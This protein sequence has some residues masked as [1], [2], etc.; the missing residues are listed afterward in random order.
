[1]RQPVRK[2]ASPSVPRNR[3]RSS[4]S[5]KI[6]SRLSPRS[7]TCK[8]PAHS[9]LTF[10][11]TPISFALCKQQGL[12]PLPRPRHL[13]A[14]GRL[15]QERPFLASSLARRAL[16]T[17]V[18]QPMQSAAAIHCKVII[19][20]RLPPSHVFGRYSQTVRALPPKLF[21]NSSRRSSCPAR[22]RADVKY[23][24]QINSAFLPRIPPLS[25]PPGTIP[26]I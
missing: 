24:G 13:Y 9:M 25:R 20:S 17:R 10:L 15:L 16:E 23:P 4:S 11:A 5:R 14:R 3:P 12:T 7:R 8:A 22:S 18:H 2:P 1:M 19:A 21:R 6:A 26:R